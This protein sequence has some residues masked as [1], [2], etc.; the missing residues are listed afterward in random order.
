MQL[1]I[2]VQNINQNTSWV[3]RALL[4]PRSGTFIGFGP[5]PEYVSSGAMAQVAVLPFGVSG[6]IIV[7]GF[8]DQ[9]RFQRH[10]GANLSP[11]VLVIDTR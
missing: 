6:L 4:M 11:G 8:P 3:S 1:F 10:S 9:F 7:T 2:S 5:L